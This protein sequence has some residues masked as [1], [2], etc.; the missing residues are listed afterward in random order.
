MPKF[1]SPTAPLSATPSLRRP[2]LVSEVEQRLADYIFALPPD[3]ESVL[4]AERALSEQMGVSRP[5]LREATKRLES[6]GLV[7]IRHGI[8]V[9]II[10]DL[11][12][13]IMSA[14]DLLVPDEAE[15]LRQLTEVRIQVEPAIAALAALRRTDDDLLRLR[16]TE[17]GMLAAAT[18]EEAVAQ[19]LQFHR[20]IA[21]A[22]GNR[23]YTLLLESLSGLGY[24]SRIATMTR[25]G[26]PLAASQHGKIRQAIERGDPDAA[27]DAMR[28]NLAETS[29][30]IASLYP[31]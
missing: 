6:R 2:P 15:R 20:I 13:P 5:V 16:A 12:K 31:G 26:A 3:S 17:D 25:F 8:G 18:I 30:E 29:R 27:A 23:I 24:E 19:D 22:S 21:Q 1:S 28:S 10:R 9:R 11:H 7:E 4:P 14:I